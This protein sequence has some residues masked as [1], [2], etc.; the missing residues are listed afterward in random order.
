MYL[1]DAVLSLKTGSR[2][3]FSQN[4]RGSLSRYSIKLCNNY[5]GFAQ[6]T[7]GF[8]CDDLNYRSK[9][10]PDDLS[11]GNSTMFC[12]NCG[13][14]TN[15][16]AA[17][18]HACGKGF[19]SQARSASKSSVSTRSEA[20]VM[21]I[22]K[23]SRS[24]FWRRF[25]AHIIDVAI[26][27]TAIRLI[28]GTLSD[29][30]RLG[31]SGWPYSWTDEVG[32]LAGYFFGTPLIFES[33]NFL[34]SMTDWDSYVRT[35]ELGNYPSS[36]WVHLGLEY[37]IPLTAIFCYQVISITLW[38]HTPGKSALGIRVVGS[39]GRSPTL[40]RAI[41]RESLGKLL[42]LILWIGF[43]MTIGKQKRGLHDRISGT[44]VV[45]SARSW[46]NDGNIARKDAR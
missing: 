38:G 9:T 7:I 18:C 1:R 12:G 22:D 29:I 24:G 21:F 39:D 11:H 43:L 35:Y 14:N 8:I 25:S 32:D 19:K 40:V 20:A 15:N 17:F 41:I 6:L 45:V 34:G 33:F 23:A 28:L 2:A 42:S 4:Y 5:S 46:R 13:A 30:F 16:E 31:I 37:F 3:E 44:E 36:P 26:V 10:N 27:W